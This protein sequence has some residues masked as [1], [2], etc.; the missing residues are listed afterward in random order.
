MPTGTPIC[1]EF[2]DLPVSRQRKWQLRQSKRGLCSICG[3]PKA[4]WSATYCA[5]HH[6]AAK[7][8]A[9]EHRGCEAYESSGLGRPPNNTFDPIAHFRQWA[10]NLGAGGSG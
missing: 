3:A 10:K 7:L 1:D 4:K 8:L 9:R 5:V 2:S 6:E